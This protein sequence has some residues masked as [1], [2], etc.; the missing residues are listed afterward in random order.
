MKPSLN[1]KKLSAAVLLL[2][3]AG[4]AQALPPEANPNIT[5]YISGG[6]AQ[7]VAFDGFVENLALPGTFDLYWD[8][9]NSSNP[10]SRFRAYFFQTDNTKIPG[11]S[12][13]ATPVNVLIY[14]RSYGAAGYGVVPLLD[15]NYQ[16]KQMDIK[17]AGAVLPKQG[18]EPYY[19][20]ATT[21]LQNARSDAGISGLNPELYYGI[22]YPTAVTEDPPFPQ[23]DVTKASNTL[24]IVPIGGLTYGLAVTLDLYKVLQAAQI[25]T[26]TLPAG[27]QIGDYKNEASIPTLSRYFV[28][29][30]LA[31]KIKTWDE[32]RVIDERPIAS[33]ATKGNDLGSL[34]SFAAQAGVTAPLTNGKNL[35]TVANRNKGA[36]IGAAFSAVFLNAPGTA[37]AFHPATSPGN[38]VNGPIV[39]Q[40]PG[41]GQVEGALVDWQNGGN[42]S[43]Y[44]PDGGRHWG[45]GQNTID[46]GVSGTI[47]VDPARPFRY[48]RIDGHAGTLPNVANGSY[49]LWTEQTIQ[50][51]NQAN[52]GPSGDKLVILKK[53]ADDIGS[54]VAAAAVNQKIVSTFGPTGVFAISTS[55]VIGSNE[56]FDTSKPVVNYTYLNGGV[57]N[58]S[59]VP[60]YNSN[61]PGT[62]T[63]K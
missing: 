7:D 39:T 60:T 4:S 17:Q 53:L 8:N 13:G 25:A 43:T 10:G 31:G 33:G 55:S 26:G 34:T 52:G 57:I 42:S 32:V 3:G 41:A 38:P 50:W 14:K 30:L 62:V 15:A 24:D 49:P 51:R 47:G 48:V 9:S 22:N 5:I 61:K 40:P 12:T 54:P 45:I 20:V 16:V 23:L 46:R 35:V 11:L 1:L 27:T 58:N 18:N 21:T 29:S 56:P 63:F 44:N 19:R 28:G 2:V 59:I 6:A 37:N 36:A